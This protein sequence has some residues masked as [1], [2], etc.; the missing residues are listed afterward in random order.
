MNPAASARL[1]LV[2]DDPTF[3]NDMA[4]H[5]GPH[6]ELQIA[7][8][9]EAALLAIANGGFD[10]ILLDYDLG[11]GRPDGMHVLERLRD[12]EAAPPVIM[13]TVRNDMATVVATIRAGA[14]HYCTKPPHI[15][16][17]RNLIALG[18]REARLI[19]QKEILESELL[20]QRGGF[21]AVDRRTMAVLREAERVAAQ[22]TTVL[23]TGPCGA[24]K[25]MVARRI[26]ELS[27]RKRGIFVGVNCAAIPGELIESELFGYEQGGFTGANK[28]RKGAFEQ[29]AGGTL[30]LDEIGDAPPRLHTKLLRVLEE[31]T[32][33]RVGGEVSVEADIRVLSATS[34][35]LEADVAAGRFNEALYYRLNVY[36][37]DLPGLDQRPADVEAL[38][39]S[40]LIRFAAEAKKKIMGF[41][42]DALENLRTRKW[43]GNVRQLRNLVES[44]VIRCDGD[45]IGLGDLV[46]G[47][48][49]GGGSPFP[50]HQAKEQAMRTFKREYLAAQLRHA[51]GNITRAADLS[52]LHRQAFSKMLRD[53]GIDAAEA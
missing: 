34:R 1:L 7:A 50:Y 13:L 24:G 23:I 4:F 14:F 30:F 25:E 42:P 40:F 20:R 6:Y 2:D 35:D 15:A 22:A 39:E 45:R 8:D 41:T 10:L 38:A 36:R 29:A 33:M 3:C 12:L 47:L 28:Q 46:S 21:V 48:R 17:L 49:H 27:G 37:I 5:L 31:R 26:H 19:N 44:A 16:E 52:G 18:L 43:P 53:E 9:A 11:T 51:E 32:F